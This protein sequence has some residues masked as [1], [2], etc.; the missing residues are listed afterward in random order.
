[1]RNLLLII[2]DEHYYSSFSLSPRTMIVGQPSHGFSASYIHSMV[3]RGVF[4]CGH[5][6]CMKSMVDGGVFICGH[7]FCMKTI[8]KLYFESS[9]LYSRTSISSQASY[10]FS[11]LHIHSMADGGALI[12]KKMSYYGCPNE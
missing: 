5:V 3:D 11:S 10:T 8:G 6:F 9:N 12:P 4:V 2:I 7:I 1:M